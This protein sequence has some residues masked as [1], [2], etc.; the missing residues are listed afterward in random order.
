MCVVNICL[1]H[2]NSWGWHFHIYPLFTERFI[3]L[4]WME[5]QYREKK[6]QQE[7][8]FLPEQVGATDFW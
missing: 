2:T 4:V 6:M 5:G 7:Y 1:V 8:A 3:S